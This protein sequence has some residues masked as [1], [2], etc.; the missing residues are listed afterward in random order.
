MARINGVSLRSKSGGPEPD[1]RTK[2]L[3]SPVW[4]SAVSN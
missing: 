1:Q 2:I 3:V 4:I